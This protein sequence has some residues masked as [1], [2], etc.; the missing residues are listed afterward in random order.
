MHTPTPTPTHTPSQQ[1]Y[2]TPL[3]LGSCVRWWWGRG[4]VG[5]CAPPPT[6]WHSGHWSRSPATGC[7]NSNKLSTLYHHD[8]EREVRC[9]E[10]IVYDIS[11]LSKINTAA[12]GI[13]T[14]SIPSSLAFL[15]SSPLSSLPPHPSLP[16]FPSFYAT[17][18][19]YIQVSIWS[20]E[21]T[22]AVW[23]SSQASLVFVPW[24]AFSIIHTHCS[25]IILHANQGT[26]T[27]RNEANCYMHPATL[28]DIRVFLSYLASSP[29][30][31]Y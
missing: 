17:Y 21:L 22:T 20:L 24:F 2:S 23:P 16:L 15:P 4:G 18:T 3:H 31:L 25:C 12:T 5:P 9:A 14:D 11:C 26:K 13:F 7:H 28:Y 8:L 29:P 27:G 1:C 6:P 10:T 19:H 30:L